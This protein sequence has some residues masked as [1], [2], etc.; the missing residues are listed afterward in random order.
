MYTQDAVVD[1]LQMT[2]C[3]IHLISTVTKSKKRIANQ[4]IY[5]IFN[6]YINWNYTVHINPDVTYESHMWH[7]DDHC[8]CTDVS[9]GFKIPQ[10]LSCDISPW[11]KNNLVRLYIGLAIAAVNT[12]DAT[13]DVISLIMLHEEICIAFIFLHYLKKYKFEMLT[14]LKEYAN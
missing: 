14:N 1:S 5:F 9:G 6:S 13:S 11:V 10:G 2:N 4:V 12:W 7:Q 8:G 3:F